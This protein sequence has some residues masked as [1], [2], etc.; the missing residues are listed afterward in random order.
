MAVAALP[1]GKKSP[2]D[3]MR[4]KFR[5]LKN[6]IK[7]MSKTVIGIQTALQ[8]ANE[9]KRKR[10]ET[11]KENRIKQKDLQQKQAEEARLEKPNLMSSSFSNIKDSIK[12]SGG[13]IL[14]SV[15]K[16][17][18]LFAGAWLFKNIDNIKD[19]IEKAVKI[20]QD[21]WTGISNF[22]SGTFD[23]V[24][25]L[26][27]TVLAFGKNIIELDFKDK[28]G[29]LKEAF[30]DVE[31]GWKKL[32][33]AITGAEE[34]FDNPEKIEDEKESEDKDTDTDKEE[35]EGS[36]ETSGNGTSVKVDPLVVLDDNKE[37]IPFGMYDLVKS[38]IEKNPSEYDT[39]EE[40]SAALEKYGID[41]SEVKYRKNYS[42]TSDENNLEKKQNNMVGKVNQQ[43]NNAEQKLKN[44]KLTIEGK[45]KLNLDKITPKAVAETITVVAPPQR[46]D[47]ANTRSGA[48][49]YSNAMKA[50]RSG[51]DYKLLREKEALE[52]LN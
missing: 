20:I 17:I 16:I 38:E 22:V 15:L 39:K 37:L 9:L 7:S 21:V 46:S 6:N 36:D 31:L 35:K 28:S 29:R 2:I 33:G 42:S 4:S 1:P 34:T 45:N 14:N 13:G 32:S 18:G 51:D 25:G 50:Y 23:I 44:E 10:L 49:S 48:K 40:I 3:S 43:V 24:K 11:I 41:S 52:V 47:Y 12:K 19:T 5:G 8:K 27:K 30:S 26:A